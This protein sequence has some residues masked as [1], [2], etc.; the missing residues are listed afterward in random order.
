M[1]PTVK[2]S[3]VSLQKDMRDGKKSHT[4]FCQQFTTYSICILD[5][6]ATDVRDNPIIPITVIPANFYLLT[7]NVVL[8][9]SE[10]DLESHLR[11]SVEAKAWELVDMKLLF[12]LEKNSTQCS[13]LVINPAIFLFQIAAAIM[14]K[15]NLSVDPCDN[16]FR[17]ACDG[18]INNNPIPEDMPS[19]GVYPWLRH[20]VD[21]KL[22]G[23]FLLQ[24]DDVLYRVQYLTR[25]VEFGLGV[26]VY[27]VNPALGRLRLKD[28][29]F[30]ASLAP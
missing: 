23:K 27:A 7:L 24:F 13:V 17:F 11:G 8:S 1:D 28:C 19:Y 3:N 9:Y 16:F 25:K 2:N 14:S 15:V 4:Y 5:T 6:H 12:S 26:A 21:L 18:W 20:N 22:K 29:V 10:V 30:K